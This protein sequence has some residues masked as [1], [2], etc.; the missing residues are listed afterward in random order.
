[1]NEIVLKALA[2]KLHRTRTK[3]GEHESVEGID[4]FD[5]V[6]DIDLVAD[7][8]CPLPNPG[9]LHQALRPHPRAKSY[10]RRRRAAARRNPS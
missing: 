1:M 8:E 5:K 6:I 9:H 2:N 7:G 4:V 3:P 10:A